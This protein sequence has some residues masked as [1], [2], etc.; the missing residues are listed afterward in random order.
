[1]RHRAQIYAMDYA[2]EGAFGALAAP[3][4][5]ALAEDFAAAAADD[6]GAARD[7][8]D[9]AAAAANATAAGYADDG[10][11]LCDPRAARA[12]G[13]ALA[14]V[15]LGGWGVCFAIYG[16]LHKTYA[17]DRDRVARAAARDQIAARVD[18]AAAPAVELVPPRLDRDA[19]A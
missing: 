19:C 7:A 3:L 6:A 5:G 18:A 17:A 11:A 12:L 9:G 2:F 13:R 10:E 4:V 14:L 15:L 8:C 1:M 16:L